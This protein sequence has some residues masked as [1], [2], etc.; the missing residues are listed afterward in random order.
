[1]SKVTYHLNGLGCANCAAKI[2]SAVK[3]VDGV[4]EA[5]VDFSTAKLVFAYDEVSALPL[6]K[7]D[8][9]NLVHTYEPD[10]EVIDDATH[11]TASHAHENFDEKREKWRLI[12]SLITFFVALYL[13][14][15]S[16]PFSLTLLLFAYA[17]SGYK[18]IY[19]SF[20]NILRRQWF[21]ENFLMFIATVGAIA[22]GEYTEAVAVMLFYEVGEFFQDMAVGKSRRSIS[23]LINIRPEIAH[24]KTSKGIEDKTPEFVAID[25]VVLVKPGERVPLDGII[26]KGE[27]SVDVSA[28]TGESVPSFLKTDDSILSGS[29]V[30]NS[31]IEIRVTKRYQDSTVSKILELVQNATSHK[32]PTENFITK[33]AR[34]YTPVVVGLALL[35]V[36]IPTAL[37]GINTFSTWLNRGLIFLVISCPCALVI[38]VPLGFFSGI[39]NASHHGILIKGSHYLEGIN[40]IDTV[41]FDKTGTLTTGKLDIVDVIAAPPYSEQQ[42]IKVAQKIESHSNHPI[43]KAILNF[44]THEDNKI[45]KPTTDQNLLIDLSEKREEIG[46][47]GIKVRLNQTDYLAGTEKLMQKYN[48]DYPKEIN[49]VGTRVYIAKDD[50]YIG[51]IVLK[52]RI[53]TYAPELIK[54]LHKRHINTIMLTGDRHE[55]AEEVASTLRI[56]QYY[57][58]LLPEDK[59]HRVQAL[60]QQDKKV[61]FVGDGINDAPVLAG[62]TLGISMGRLGSDAAIEA[63]DIV[64]MNDGL[65]SIYEAFTISKFTK[66]I[67]SQNIVFAIGI[68]IIIMLLGT[69]GL[70][71]MWMAIFADVGVALLAVLNAMRILSFKPAPL[72]S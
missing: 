60:I 43:A 61:A 58:S 69:V 1:M 32:A 48:I 72:S 16:S 41:V 19:K 13:K 51:T 5:Y 12:I 14:N 66:K 46:G 22:I 4:Q 9:E 44:K 11:N 24:V 35:I 37:Y 34:Y 26:I 8:V 52:D 18:V 70:S 29:V 28:L 63:S 6:S 47:L 57:A 17:L 50:V 38:S 67:V 54:A 2:E 7:G 45:N 40:A 64:I 53:K 36:A 15:T 3:K 68:K 30:L 56:D 65:N 33:F 20:R 55:V 49:T 21:D 27:T 62:A 39:G 42:L 10:V 59:F 31:V 23:A 71:S 25:D